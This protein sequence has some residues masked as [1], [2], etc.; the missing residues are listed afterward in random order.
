MGGVGEVWG[1]GWGG[2]NI[3]LRW[4][5]GRKKGLQVSG[6]AWTYLIGLLSLANEQLYTVQVVVNIQ[7]IH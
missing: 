7:D 6:T 2:G 4:G 1:W 3:G 5:W